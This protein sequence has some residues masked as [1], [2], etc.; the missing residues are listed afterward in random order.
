MLT[1]CKLKCPVAGDPIYVTGPKVRVQ[2]W[3]SDG[4]EVWAVLGPVSV[5]AAMS[6]RVK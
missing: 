4:E 2:E 3:S 1:R 5:C 6:M